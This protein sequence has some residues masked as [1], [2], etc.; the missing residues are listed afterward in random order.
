MKAP[1]LVAAELR[2]AL[3]AAGDD[4]PDYAGLMRAAEAGIQTIAAMIRDFQDEVAKELATGGYWPMA[5]APIKDG[6][7]ILGLVQRGH[8]GGRMTV[9]P[10]VLVLKGGR[11]C[12]LPGGWT[13]P[14]LG[15]RPMPVEDIVTER[16]TW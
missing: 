5:T 16:R 8:A 4:P 3:V 1:V 6:A 13:A 15:W 7:R 10:R 11:W 2:A 9:E 14:V 12:S